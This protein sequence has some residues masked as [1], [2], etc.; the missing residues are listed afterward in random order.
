VARRFIDAEVLTRDKH[1]STSAQNNF[2][3]SILQ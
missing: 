3:V 1:R 2:L